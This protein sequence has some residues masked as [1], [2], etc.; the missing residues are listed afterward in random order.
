MTLVVDVWHHVFFKYNV[1][2]LDSIED[3]AIVIIY[4]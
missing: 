4:R 2:L 3:L 1:C